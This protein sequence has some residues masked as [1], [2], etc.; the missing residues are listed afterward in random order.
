LSCLLDTTHTVHGHPRSE[1]RGTLCSNRDCPQHTL[2]LEILKDENGKDGPMCGQA[3]EGLEA[4]PLPGGGYRRWLV[5]SDG[6]HRQLK[7]LKPTT[8]ES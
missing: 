1:V 4:T 2:C 5:C 3:W 8:K 7:D 6:H